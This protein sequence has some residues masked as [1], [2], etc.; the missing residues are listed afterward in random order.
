MTLFDKC[1]IIGIGIGSA[2]IAVE[3]I[4]ILRK[5]QEFEYDS[6]WFGDMPFCER[7]KL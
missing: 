5:E 7:W 2:L 3:V 1:L 6:N 4:R